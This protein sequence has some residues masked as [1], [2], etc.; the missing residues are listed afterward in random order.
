MS[1]ED[2][3]A[4]GQK[5]I[6]CRAAGRATSGAAPQSWGWAVQPRAKARAQNARAT[7][8]AT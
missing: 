6:L 3:R 5:E 4:R 1:G 7:Q 8:K 2:N